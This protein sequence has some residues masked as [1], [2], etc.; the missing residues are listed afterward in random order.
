VNRADGRD[1]VIVPDCF[2][3]RRFLTNLWKCAQH[4]NI[5]REMNTSRTTTFRSNE[6][7]ATG[8]EEAIHTYS[9]GFKELHEREAVA[10]YIDS[11]I[12]K[13]GPVV[14]GY[15]SWHPFTCRPEA[16]SRD[17]DPKFDPQGFQGLDHTIFFRDAFVTAP[18]DGEDRVIE[19]AWKL[20]NPFVG[21]ED[22][23]GVPLY[24][25]GTTPVLITCDGIPK[26]E[27]GTISKRFALGSM[28]SN[29]LPAWKWASCGETWKDMR[30]HVLGLPCGSRSSLF[31]NQD[32]GKA[33]REAFDLLNRHEL[34]GPVRR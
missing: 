3:A 9:R 33:L 15:P 17:F 7:A 22:I 31:V 8:R 4:G 6:A 18:Y 5:V 28:L 19:S 20:R 30:R 10:S 25:Y 11:L 16:D 23:R 2:G 13:Y 14:T 1:P 34:F 27:D 24:N 21:V 26:E 32:T 12:E 29:E